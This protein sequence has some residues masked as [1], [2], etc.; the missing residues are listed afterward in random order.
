MTWGK[1]CGYEPALL[2]SFISHPEGGKIWHDFTGVFVK[3]E[4]HVKYHPN[5]ILDTFENYY[6]GR[7]YGVD[8]LL[9]KEW[10]YVG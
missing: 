7:I 8:E 9:K 3:R 2:E 6:N 5:R 4:D 1:K 10:L